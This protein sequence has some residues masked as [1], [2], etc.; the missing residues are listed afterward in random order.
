MTRTTL[1]VTSHEVLSQRLQNRVS[2]APGDLHFHSCAAC[3]LISSFL[4]GDAYHSHRG[5]TT[6][7]Q[8]CDM[9]AFF[10]FRR[11]TAPRCAR[12]II[13][14]RSFQSPN[15]RSTPPSSFCLGIV[16]PTS[17]TVLFLIQLILAFCSRVFAGCHLTWAKRG[18]FTT[19]PP[20]RTLKTTDFQW[21]PACHC[22][23]IGFNSCDDSE[24][25]TS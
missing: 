21:H 4:Y 18:S 14:S 3:G 11:Q 16:Q 1:H 15:A 2:I 17:S 12:E 20:H 7:R 5:L 10:G 24:G 19:F 8:P 25:N 9:C 6:T 22:F 23:N 13:S